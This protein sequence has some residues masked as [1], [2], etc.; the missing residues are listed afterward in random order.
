MVNLKEVG[1]RLAIVF[2]SRVDDHI[3]AKNFKAHCIE[4]VAWLA[5]TI[6]MNE[7]RLDGDQSLHYYIVD[8][9]LQYIDIEFISILYTFLLNGI[10]NSLKAP[11]VARLASLIS[12]KIRI[13]FVDGIVSQMDEW[14]IEGFKFILLSSESSKTVLMDKDS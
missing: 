10:P 2:P 6:V 11:F 3:K 14:V 12:C 5:C 8:L 9:C 7:I 4:N 1:L 13:V